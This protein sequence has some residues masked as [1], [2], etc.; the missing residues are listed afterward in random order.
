MKF[1]CIECGKTLDESNFH[2]NVKNESKD[3]LNKKHK[4]QVCGNV[5]TKTMVDCSYW[6][7][8]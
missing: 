6:T 1:L 3:C 7:R 5:F 2:K 8:T 4:F